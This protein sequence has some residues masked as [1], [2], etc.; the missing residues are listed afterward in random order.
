MKMYANACSYDDA[1]SFPQQLV[2]TL[3]QSLAQTTNGLPLCIYIYDLVEQHTLSSS[4][5][6]ADMLGY[7]PDTI[8]AMGPTGLAALIHPDDLNRVAAHY[9]RFATLLH[10]EIITI[11]YRMKRADGCWCWLR[12][13]EMSLVQAIDGFPLQVLGII[14][15]ITALKPTDA[16]R[17]P[18]L[19][20]P[21]RRR[22]STLSFP[23]VAARLKQLCL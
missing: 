17:P 10:G 6:V 21:L 23:R 15:D 18:L 4:E 8:H 9:Q 12:S 16:N 2:H 3:K 7:T 13:Q 19:K 11:A 5:S 14:Q 22:L 20:R 1:T